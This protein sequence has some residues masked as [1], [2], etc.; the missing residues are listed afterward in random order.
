MVLTR[1]QTS[2]QSQLKSENIKYFSDYDSD[3]SFPERDS[4]GATNNIER[5]N[6]LDL[7]RDDERSIY[8]QVFIGMNTQIRELTSIVK[9]FA[10][11]NF[12]D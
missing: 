10:D 11:Q 12:L 4:R 9:T 5:T 3:A 1:S 8:D 7:E 2:C 6:L